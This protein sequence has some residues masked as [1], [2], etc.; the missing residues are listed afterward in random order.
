MTN[1]AA[2]TTPLRTVNRCG[3]LL[4]GCSRLA[5]W[6]L[7]HRQLARERRHLACFDE[8]MLKDIGLSRADVE[9]EIAKGFWRH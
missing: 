3:W 4:A 5:G 7:E 2:R 1:P 9:Q 6:Y 8:H